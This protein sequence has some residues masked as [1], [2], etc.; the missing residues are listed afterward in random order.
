MSDVLTY[1]LDPMHSSARFS[2]RH[3]M[4]AHVRG[5]FTHVTGTAE[6]N[7]TDMSH[8]KVEATIDATSFHT[9]NDQR[10]EHVKSDHF[11]DVA[12]YPTLTFHS[13]ET[14]GT[15][16]H[17]EIAGDLT[18]HGVARPVT[19]HV[20]EISPEI[21]DPWGNKRMSVTATTQIKRSDFGITFNAPLESGGVM[22]SDEVEVTLELQLTRPSA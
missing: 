1:T 9:G 19:L 20:G 10:D 2:I 16:G 15:D 17:T 11:L 3:L 21:T 4:I 5:S 7:P 18:L 13:R 12:Q 14:S 22:L 8:L 6:Y